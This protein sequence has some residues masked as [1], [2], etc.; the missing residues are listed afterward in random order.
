MSL[1]DSQILLLIIL[2]I[3]I[4]LLYYYYHHY[5]SCTTIR[6][7]YINTNQHVPYPE[8]YLE[9]QVEDPP[10]LLRRHIKTEAP[11]A[12][13]MTARAAPGR[14]Y[15]PTVVCFCVVCFCFCC[16]RYGFR[17]V[18]SSI[19]RFPAKAGPGTV[20]DGPGLKNGT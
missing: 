12:G 13:R 9:S 8:Q 1:S 20:T 15:E 5:S 19:G 3:H 4:L 7:S 11:P 17:C 10:C 16:S 14:A 2:F 18:G 6:T